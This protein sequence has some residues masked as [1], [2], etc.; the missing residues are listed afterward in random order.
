MEMSGRQR[1]VTPYSRGK[2]PV[3][4]EQE[5]G[6]APEL[7]WTVVEKRVMSCPSGD[8]TAGRPARRLVNVPTEYMYRETEREH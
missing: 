3:A 2:I 1:V 5:A 8:T 7:V 4:T 6:S